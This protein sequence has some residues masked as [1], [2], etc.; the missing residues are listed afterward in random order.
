MFDF[1]IFFF[2]ILGLSFWLYTR[3]SLAKTRGSVVVNGLLDVVDVFRDEKGIPHIRANHD[4]DVFFGLGYAHAQD[5]MWQLELQRRVCHGSLSQVF[6]PSSLQTDKLIRTLAFSDSARSVINNFS[7]EDLLYIS[8]YVKGINAWISERH[9]LPIEFYVC[10]VRPSIWKNIDVVMWSKMMS[11]TLGSNWQSELLRS[12]LASVLGKKRACELLGGS[13]EHI[14]EEF[15]QQ[16]Q[17]LM[18]RLSNLAKSVN[19][20]LSF[21]GVDVGSN[22]WV[23]SG[24]HTVTGKPILANDPHLGA[25]IPSAWYLAN[26]Q[27]DKVSVVGATLPGLPFVPIG[28]NDKIAWGMT[29]TYAD[30]QDLLF[31]EVCADNPNQYICDDNPLDFK[32]VDEVIYV[33]GERPVRFTRRSTVNGPVVSDVVGSDLE[34]VAVMRWT[35][36]DQNDTTLVSFRKINMAH[37]WSSFKEGLSAFIS[38]SQNFVYADIDGNIGYH[39]AG[40][41]PIRSNGEGD[42]PSSIQTS[43][44]WASYVPFDELPNQ[45]NPSSGFI[46]TANNDVTGKGY[47]Y[48]ISHE[49]APDYRYKRIKQQFDEL[50]EGDRRLTVDDVKAIQLD[51]VSLMAQQLQPYLIQIRGY[52]MRERQALEYLK[53][54]TGEM[55]ALK[56]APTLFNVWYTELLKETILSDLDQELREEYL[57]G[58]YPIFSVKLLLSYLAE[59]ANDDGQLSAA[60]IDGLL[61]KS[62]MA[63]I[64]FIESN[65][66]QDMDTWQWGKLH[67]LHYAHSPFDRVSWLKVLFSRQVASGGDA[68]TVSVGGYSYSNAYIQYDHPS[69]RQII[70]LSN[71]KGSCFM[72]SVGQSANVFSQHY[73]DLLYIQQKSGYAPMWFGSKVIPG[74]KRLQ[75]VPKQD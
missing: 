24:S 72:Q 73:D 30:C 46:A 54:W 21:G 1:F 44:P 52:T 40:R 9:W 8:S 69:Y 51:Q 25:M 37:D 12:K 35:A 49:F 57:G 68:Y 45:Y 17:V 33:R 16:N 13:D 28:H 34:K 63:A 15:Y 65:L 56:V 10:G 36:L 11:W 31:Q 23:V 6:G 53:P 20:D 55:N 75:L 59:N 67:Q 27:G 5:R 50:T 74:S 38:P 71:W 70:D 26:L 61:T 7:D 66:G 41:I 3:L 32:L 62:F 60:F 48:F 43:K 14:S 64:D 4:A 18:E 22:N 47:K 29:N 2:V 58:R 42:V 19:K 39:F